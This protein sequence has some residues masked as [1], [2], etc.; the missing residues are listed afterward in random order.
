MLTT[1]LSRVLLFSAKHA[2]LDTESVGMAKDRIAR[3]K[4]CASSCLRYLSLLSVLVC[5]KIERNV[6]TYRTP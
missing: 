4:Y 5:L 3:I 1:F 6:G 2:S